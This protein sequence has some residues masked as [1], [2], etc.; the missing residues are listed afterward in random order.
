MPTLASD[1]LI[2]LPLPS[3]QTRDRLAEWV[4]SV[5]TITN[6]MDITTQFM[7]D[8]EA[9][10]QYL[11]A[12]TDDPNYDLLILML[13][14]SSRKKSQEIAERI[15]EIWPELGKPLVVCWPVGN[16]A[17]QAFRVL[18]KK[19]VP[20]FFHPGR[21]LSAIGHFVRHGVRTKSFRPSPV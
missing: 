2:D 4:P 20:L 21:C 17:G 13:T 15:A 6:P 16:M 10:A 14:F 19:G 11:R 1:Q 7:N 3:P 8:P 18:E 9:M 5:A 12:F